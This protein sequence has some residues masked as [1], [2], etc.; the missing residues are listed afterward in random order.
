METTP[1]HNPD[2]EMNVLGAALLHEAARDSLLSHLSAEDFYTEDHRVV[3]LAIQ[4][5]ILA[6]DNVDI[7]LLALRLTRDGDL[8]EGTQARPL[9][10]SIAAVA[11]T[12]PQ[13]PTY[14][15]EIKALT[16]ARAAIAAAAKLNEDLRL[17]NGDPAATAAAIQAATSGLNEASTTTSSSPWARIDSLM[18]PDA[19]PVID[20]TVPTGFPD[21]DHI[22]NGGF[23]PGQLVVIA[24]RPAQGKSTLGMDIAR[25]ATITKGVPGLVI[26]LEMSNQELAVRVM[27]AEGRVPMNLI[28]NHQIDQRDRSTLAGVATRV[29]QAPLFMVDNVEPKLPEI[30]ALILRAIRELNIQFVILD[31]AGLITSDGIQTASRE[32]TVANVSRSFKGLARTNQI[33]VIL[34]AQLNRG[35]EQRSDHRPQLSDLR[36]SGQLEQDADAALMI[37][38]PATYDPASERAGEVDVIVAKQRQGPLGT[39]VLAVQGHYGRF[40]SMAR[41][42]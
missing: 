31:Y 11:V 3:F 41:G 39:A 5:A 40:A 18:D 33:V 29:Q 37:Y 15:K 25:H 9:L 23:R 6:G 28:L 42:D 22:L 16:A 20:P 14:A 35:P 21:L 27:A 17:A 32:Q 7:P 2:F 38:Q 4:A 36:E 24:G 13:V 34:I 8:S 19:M 1:P 26:S 12:T 30:M 10:A